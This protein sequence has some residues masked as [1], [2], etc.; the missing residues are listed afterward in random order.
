MKKIYLLAL[1]V[2]AA[3]AG[4]AQLKQ[5]PAA[6]GKT[7]LRGMPTA[8]PANTSENRV[9]IWSNDFSNCDDWTTNDA[10]SSG[11]TD[12]IDGLDWQCGTDGP[13]GPAAIDPI[14]SF[15][16]D[17]GFMMIDSDL[18]G[19]ETPANAWVENAWFQTA[20]PID[21][22]AYDNISLR[23]QTFYRMW[24]N[25]S[26]DGNEYCLV[27]VSTDGVTWPDI[28]TYEVS[29]ADPGT[30]FELWPT[31]GTQ[32]PVTNPT[33][34]VF[35]ISEVAGAADQIW[36]RFRWVG[37]WGYSW[38]VDDI[39]LYET[40]ANDL[41]I[42]NNWCGDIINN[43]EYHAIPTGQV[44][45]TAFGVV[46]ANYGY[47]DNEATA[48]FTVNGTDVYTASGTILAGTIDTLWTE[49]F[50][51]S[52]DLGNYDVV[53]T[54]PEDD[55]LSGNSAT[56]FFE[57]TDI[58]FGQNSNLDMFQRTFNS[59]QEVAFGCLYDIREDAQAGG[60]NV[61]FGSNT[62]AGL[63]AQVF[64]YEVLTNI[65]DLS[66]VAASEVFTVTQ[67]MIDNGGDGIYTTIGF[68]DSGAQD[69]TA[70]TTYIAEIRKYESTDRMYLACN[71]WDDDFGV[72]NYGPFGT[73]G[74]SN[75][76]NGWDF[77]P[78]VRLLLDPSVA[79]EEVASAGEITG[80]SIYPNP[81]DDNANISFNLLNNNNVKVIVRDMTGRLVSSENY[82]NRTSGQNTINLNVSSLNAGIYSVTVV[83]GSS[84]FTS[85]IVVR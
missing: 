14:A 17:N 74:A 84:S 80:A 8:T 2:C 42:L 3:V 4:N 19:G 29:E 23:F 39:E 79:V 34:K 49:P 58:E 73:G 22:S 32:D 16:A 9:V 71:Y 59:D 25:G 83:A 7:G 81:A 68:N 72:A 69:V 1:A 13:S 28:T 60:V 82:G 62:D 50:T 75:W 12:Y 10:F 11:N 18:F 36:L 31:M 5:S 26:S 76:F 63:Q 46:L 24:D 66:E 33:L 45:E 38:M 15:S 53:V 64:L 56:N 77:T 44:A 35:N 37:Y 65:Q 30:R 70:G 47:N 78:A 55:E 48:T 51:P 57:I 85:E 6:Q 21:V 54:V 20:N 52:T 67:E 43:F 27:E 61:L 40:P 41:T